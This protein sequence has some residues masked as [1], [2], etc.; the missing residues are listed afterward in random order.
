MRPSP[1]RNPN[2]SGERASGRVLGGAGADPVA[3]AGG[4]VVVGVVG[5]GRFD[6]GGA[7][8]GVGDQALGL[9]PGRAEDRVGVATGRLGGPA[10]GLLGAPAGLADLLGGL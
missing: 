3:V 5:V 8:V 9:G 6:L 2:S 10:G 1:A 4:T 7:A